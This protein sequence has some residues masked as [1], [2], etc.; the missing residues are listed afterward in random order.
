MSPAP[1]AAG[2]RTANPRS[3]VRSHGDARSSAIALYRSGV[4]TV[5]AS[6]AEI[7]YAHQNRGRRT[8][9]VPGLHDTKVRRAR[10]RMPDHI[11]LPTERCWSCRVLVPLCVYVSGYG[12]PPRKTMQLTEGI[13][14]ANFCF[15][16][17]YGRSK[18]LHLLLKMFGIVQISVKRRKGL[19][20]FRPVVWSSS[21]SC[22]TA[23]GVLRSSLLRRFWDRWIRLPLTHCH[24]LPCWCYWPGLVKILIPDFSTCTFERVICRRSF[25]PRR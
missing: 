22:R 7:C 20:I 19:W 15:R 21:V 17:K 18:R 10:C 3:K 13:Y 11:I 9:K 8:C 16:I 4:T 2:R 25:F 23:L 5:N 14:K 6:S 12:S 1:G 24:L